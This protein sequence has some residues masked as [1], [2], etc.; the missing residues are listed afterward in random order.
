MVE[1]ARQSPPFFETVQAV[2]KKYGRD[3]VEV[4]IEYAITHQQR[5]AF[6]VAFATSLSIPSSRQLS[7][8]TRERAV[9]MILEKVPENDYSEYEEWVKIINSDIFPV[10]TEIFSEPQAET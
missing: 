7:K 5:E 8:E 6:F 3:I 4:G 2:S 9:G 10:G 1:A